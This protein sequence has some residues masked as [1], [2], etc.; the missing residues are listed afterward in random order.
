MHRW[1]TGGKI[2]GPAFSQYYKNLVKLY[3]EI[4]REFIAPEG[5][6][7]VDVG[8]KKEYFSD[9]SKP[10]RIDS[11]AKAEEELLF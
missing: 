10:P 8:G 5:I 1:E 7:E 3:P 6:V 11:Q 4:Q 9:I 2:A